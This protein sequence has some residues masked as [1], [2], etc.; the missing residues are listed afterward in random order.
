MAGE[1]DAETVPAGARREDEVRAELG[2]DAQP[3]P[4]SGKEE[5]ETEIAGMGEE[6]L[7]RRRRVMVEGIDELTPVPAHDERRR[8]RPRTAG[9]TR[10]RWATQMVE[11]RMQAPPGM[12]PAGDRRLVDDLGDPTERDDAVG[13]G[14]RRRQRHE[15]GGGIVVGDDDGRPVLRRIIGPVD[16]PLCGGEVDDPGDRRPGRRARRSAGD[17]INRRQRRGHDGSRRIAGVRVR[18]GEEIVDADSGE[19]DARL[20][21]TTGLPRSQSGTLS[22]RFRRLVGEGNGDAEANERGPRIEESGPGPVRR[23]TRG[24]GDADD[25]GGVGVVA[26]AQADPNADVRLHVPGDD[27]QRPLGREDEMDAQRPAEGGKMLEQFRGPGMRGHEG[28]ELVD[29]DDEPWGRDIEVEDVG[30][31]A[32]GE[33]PFAPRDLRTDGDERPEGRS[34]VEVV[35]DAVGVRQP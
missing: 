25:I 12:H 1:T 17:V 7:Q 18:C 19:G 27:A 6:A 16:L 29:D 21:G 32:V 35:E 15:H 31:P 10:T 20:H 8:S 23:K 30:A 34:R 24:I 28:V 3:R 22:G 33:Q 11:D 4:A 2:G 13:D 14:C 5:R 26:H 9:G